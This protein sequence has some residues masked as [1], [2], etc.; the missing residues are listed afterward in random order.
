MRQLLKENLETRQGLYFFLK[1]IIICL[2]AN[3]TNVRGKMIMEKRK[4]KY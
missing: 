2:Y 3:G 1:D 4:D